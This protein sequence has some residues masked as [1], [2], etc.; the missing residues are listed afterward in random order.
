[1]IDMDILDEKEIL[2]IREIDVSWIAETPT[3]DLEIISHKVFKELQVRKEN[4]KAELINRM[5]VAIKQFR[6]FAPLESDYYTFNYSDDA[7]EDVEVEVDIGEVLD[8]IVK[9]G[10]QGV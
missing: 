1:M 3:K 10:W 8:F 2:E 6:D 4:R 7:C 5:Q 9:R